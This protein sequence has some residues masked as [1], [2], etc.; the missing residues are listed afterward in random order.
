MKND[1]D[2]L[3]HVEKCFSFVDALKFN[4][5]LNMD[6]YYVLDFGSYNVLQY[7]NDTIRKEFCRF[8]TVEQIRVSIWKGGFKINY[9]SSTKKFRIIFGMEFVTA[10]TFSK[11][12]SEYYLNCPALMI[13][14]DLDLKNIEE[15][16]LTPSYLG[17]IFILS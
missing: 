17:F 12:M 11:A 2:L 15:V 3:G 8:N 9:N 7:R 14:N 13:E 5:E 10:D 1:V 4:K 16:L 6:K